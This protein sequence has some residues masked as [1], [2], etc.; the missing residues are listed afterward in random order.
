[1]LGDYPNKQFSLSAEE[2]DA[3][4]ARFQPV[5]GDV[6]HMPTVLSGHLGILRRV[7]RDGQTLFGAADV[8]EWLDNILDGTKSGISLAWERAEKDI[9]GW[10]WTLDPAIKVAKLTTAFSN[11]LEGRATGNLVNTPAPAIAPSLT[12]RQR[13]EK[14][15]MPIIDRLGKRIALFAA[16]AGSTT[17]EPTAA[18]E[19]APAPTTPGPGIVLP[20][21]TPAPAP[22][23]TTTTT[24]TTPAP[25]G[26]GLPPTT[27]SAPGLD[28]PEMD[29]AT[30]SFKA[31]QIAN[32][33][34]R[35]ADALISAG[36]FYSAQRPLLLALFTAA[37]YDNEAHGA[38]LVTFSR[39][40]GTVIQDRVEMLREVFGSG[41]THSLFSAE[42]PAT[43]LNGNRA[44]AEVQSAVQQ[45][46]EQAKKFNAE[47][48]GQYLAQPATTNGNGN[49]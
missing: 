8:P 39:A 42:L 29:D 7:W 28:E 25:A 22:Q 14:R 18:P 38:S 21:T 5:Q 17:P 1:M 36:H 27:F 10:G 11:T 3:A 41:P 12:P 34:E 32:T 33:A 16:G 9:K 2:A 47:H 44:P 46:D 30:A 6:E 35:E 4:I 13:K 45:G 43:I 31:D 40:N 26:P 23:P 24:T 37:G 15:L 49:H 19:P 48:F 20:T